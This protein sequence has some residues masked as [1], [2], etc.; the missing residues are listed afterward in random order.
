VPLYDIPTAF[1]TGLDFTPT[2]FIASAA[3]GVADITDGQM[4]FTI[5]GQDENGNNVAITSISVVESGAYNLFGTGTAATQVAVGASLSVK[6]T[7]IDGV[8]VAPITMFGNASL[9]RDLVANPGMAQT[10]NLS[11]MLDLSAQLT[12]LGVPYVT[13]TTRAE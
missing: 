9:S 8:A 4:N 12:T 10:W 2:G 6:V 5:H 1:A 13:G 3:G 7:E 11:V